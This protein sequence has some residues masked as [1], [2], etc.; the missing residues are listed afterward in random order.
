MRTLELGSPGRLRD[1]L[2]ALVLEGAKTATAT[3]LAEYAEEGEEREFPGERLALLDN[4]GAVLAELQVTDV[5]TVPFGEVPWGFAE[6]EGEGYTD[7]SHWRR[8]HFDFWRDVEGRS[9]DETTPVVCMHFTR[10]ISPPAGP[11][12]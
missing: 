12:L 3:L 1:E 8:A 10:T 7:L 6:A 5:M 4:D 11:A 2:N 9:V